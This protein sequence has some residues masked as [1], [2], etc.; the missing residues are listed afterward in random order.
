M[1]P[2]LRTYARTLRLIATLLGATE[3]DYCFEG[4]FRFQ[5]DGEWSLVVSA[6]DA[7]RFKFEA[8]LRS[9]A[10]ARMWSL[11]EDTARIE[12][13]VLSVRDEAAALAV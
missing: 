10:K 9:R 6:D 13:L 12:A 2:S 8:C 11:A 7:G 5:L 4:R 1:R 3:A